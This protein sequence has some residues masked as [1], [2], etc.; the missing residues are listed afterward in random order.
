MPAIM[1]NYDG[2]LK[3][4]NGLQVHKATGP[5]ESPT[6]P[7]KELSSELAP[8]LAVFFQASLDQ[9]VI[10]IDWKTAN[11]VPVY[12]KDEKNRPENYRPISLTSVM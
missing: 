12:K 7:L 2:V 10:L 3:L 9:G 11:V 1:V 6:I 8:V 5:D 4:L